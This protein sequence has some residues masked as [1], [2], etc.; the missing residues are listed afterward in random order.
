MLQ[1]QRPVGHVHD[2]ASH[3]AQR[4]RAEVPPS[5][6]T[7]GAV[8]LAVGPEGSGAEPEVPVESLGDRFRLGALR[9]AL[10]PGGPVRP[11][12]DLAHLSDYSGADPLHGAADG[13]SGVGLVAHLRGHA[14]LLGGLGH[15]SGFADGVGQ[16]LLAVDVFPQPHGHHRGVAMGVIGGGDGHRVEAFC[17]LVEHHAEVAVEPGL[18][19]GLS[20]VFPLPDAA[21][22]VDVAQGDDLAARP[23]G[24]RDL[25][26]PF[27]SDAD[28]PDADALCGAESEFGNEGRNGHGRGGLFEEK[29][30]R[31]SAVGHRG[32]SCFWARS[33][34]G[35]GHF[36]ESTR[37]GARKTPGNGSGPVFGRCAAWAALS[38]DPSNSE[39]GEPAGA[40]ETAKGRQNLERAI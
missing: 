31:A 33:R 7:E 22:V 32:F 39:R 27:A 24:P 21:I 36:V 28:A 1:I 3:V 35:R 12:V 18:G 13:L 40:D 14:V 25:A 8:A 23:G 26:G 16:R 30:T 2:V 5:P 34:M 15:E 38:A 20:G 6:P 19:E 37:R 4:A 17:L 11:G 9:Y 10:G 29:A